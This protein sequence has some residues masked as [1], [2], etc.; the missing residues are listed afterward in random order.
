M[1]ARDSALPLPAPLLLL[2]LSAT[3]SLG[4]AAWQENIRPKMYVQL[5]AEDVYRF[6]GNDTHTDYFRLVVH[7]GHNLLVGGRNLVHNLSSADLT[8]IQR[9]TWFS[10]E[11]DTK[12]CTMKGN[13]DEKCQNYIRVLTKMSAGRYLICGTNSYRPLCREYSIQTSGYLMEKEKLGQAVCPYSPNINSTAVFVDGELYSG[14]YADFS[15]TDPRIYRDPLQTEQYDS[16]SLNSPNFV[17]SFAHGDYVYFFFRE[18]AVEYI[19]CGKS[20]YSRVARVCKSDKG[21]PQRFRSGWTSYL[22]TRLNCSVPGDFPFYFDEIQSTS[23]LIEGNYGGESAKVIYGVFTTPPNSISGSA[24]CAFNLQDISKTFEGSFKEQ[25]AINSNWLPVKTAK[26]PDPRPGQ[27]VNDSRTLPDLTLNFIKMHPL[28]DESVN[29]FFGQPIVIRTSFHYRFTQIAVDPQVKT[30]GGKAYDVLFIGT[31]NGKVIK[32]VNAE[33]ADNPKKVNSVVIEEIQ[34]F[35]PNV[36]IRNLKVVRD[37][38]VTEGRLVVVSDAEI[39]AIRLHRCYSDKIIS[40]SECVAL[41]D[42]YCAWDKQ[43]QKCRSMNSARWNDE[44]SF[45]QSIATGVHSSCPASKIVGKDAGS[46]GGLS[47]S[48][49]KSFSHDMSRGGKEIPDG[50][51][52]N[53]M[54]DEQ[55][56]N[57]PEVSSAE[58]TIP[59]YTVETL[60][61][62]VVAGSVAAL[63][64]GFATGYLC[65]RKCHKDDD[66]NLPYPDTEYEYFEQRQNV[67]SRLTVEPKL[68]SQEEVTYAEP[69]HIPPSKVLSQSPKGTLRKGTHPS[70]PPAGG[71]G[72]AE[73]MFQFSDNYTPPPRDPYAHQ[74]GRDNFGTLRSHKEGF[75]SHRTR[76]PMGDGY[77]TTR[78][79]KK[80]Y[81]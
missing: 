11:T 60:V 42:P 76:N 66:D 2:L 30:P 4:W 62:A 38:S 7:D 3:C 47:S 53:I 15:G 20:I 52:I 75:S 59:Q 79:V 35:P 10:P 12:M 23:D 64:V 67:N 44:K 77:N 70:A 40:C 46:L 36:A 34:V 63:V 69:I 56:R 80:V 31:D 29:S 57:G 71:A 27:C 73:T 8:E 5:G 17:S 18:G 24:V 72:A 41:Q 37:K 78:S 28:M 54:Q 48:F 43:G 14:T 33:S 21:G 58:S 16:I 26:V 32:A 45:Y 65:G 74:R 19:N 1:S 9:L 55:D 13:D 50:E 25:T 51:V 68:L 81:L 39:Q 22:K 6:T 61:I 49:P